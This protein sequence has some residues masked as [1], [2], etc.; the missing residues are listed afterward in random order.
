MWG[1]QGRVEPT[2]LPTLVLRPGQK[3]KTVTWQGLVETI[4]SIP[5]EFKWEN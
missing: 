2:Q 5:V 1:P 4:S 3:A